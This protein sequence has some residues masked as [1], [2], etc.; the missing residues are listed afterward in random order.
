MPKLT[1][2]E[3]E[4]KKKRAFQIVCSNPGIKNEDLAHQVDVHPRTIT[5]WI[6]SEEWRKWSSRA[7]NVM[8]FSLQNK[9]MAM[10]ADLLDS[11]GKLVRGEL[12]P[13]Q[14]RNSTAL[15]NIYKTR[16]EMAG[17]INKKGDTINNTLIDNSKNEV[18][19]VH[20][21][22]M[23]PDQLFK[24]VTQNEAPKTLE[25]FTVKREESE[26]TEYNTIPVAQEET[27][28]KPK[29]GKKKHS[30]KKAKLEIDID[31]EKLGIEI[32]KPE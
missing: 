21:D 2:D 32:N 12:D 29:K 27:V 15:V 17:L 13:D 26:Y 14:S 31:L 22:Q 8:N 24:F 6:N 11:I 4:A 3:I 10:D 18:K 28:S 30:V 20:I 25:D 9:I 5:S 1:K 16:L 19:Q 23:S 7:F